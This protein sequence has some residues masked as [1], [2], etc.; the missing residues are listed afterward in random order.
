M[1]PPPR[2]QFRNSLDLAD[3]PVAEVTP[4]T[5]SH[6]LAIGR[7]QSSKG[8]Q[9]LARSLSCRDL[10]GR[11]CGTVRR[12]AVGKWGCTA[13]SLIPAV[14]PPP[15][16][17][18]LEKPRLWITYPGSSQRLPKSGKGVLSK[19]GSRI[20]ISDQQA[21]EREYP[22]VELIDKRGAGS[23]VE[24][25]QLLPVPGTATSRGLRRLREGRAPTLVRTGH[26]ARAL[27]VYRLLLSASYCSYPELP[28][29]W[30]KN[31]KTEQKNEAKGR[32]RASGLVSAPH[33]RS[34]STRVLV[35][36]RK[37]AAGTPVYTVSLIG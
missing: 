27:Q 31:K 25:A 2:Q 37:C 9:H 12:L 34:S 13:A 14:L 16:P 7:P 36:F 5:K 1:H 24:V 23:G 18:Y 4:I 15:V 19:V 6:R 22:A 28:V 20:S 30:R 21:E 32:R 33:N 10:L 26:R 11:A 35:P 29:R 8:L 17:G 3:F